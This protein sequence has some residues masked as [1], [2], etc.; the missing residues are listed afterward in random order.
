MS[1]T[2]EKNM[3]KLGRTATLYIHRFN[4][5]NGK[6]QDVIQIMLDTSNPQTDLSVVQVLPLSKA[7]E[8]HKKLGNLIK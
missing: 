4:Q 7:K 6:N 8:L 2:K 3:I 5:H 1:N